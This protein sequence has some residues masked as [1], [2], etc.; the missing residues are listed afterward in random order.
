MG[1]RRRAVGLAGA[2]AL[3]VSLLPGRSSAGGLYFSDRGVRPLGRAGAF[4]AGADDAGSIAYNP[5]GIA[6][7]GNQLL[8]DASWLQYSSVYQRRARLQQID[9]NTGD[10]VGAP[11]EQT[12]PAVEGSTP[13]LPIPTIVYTDNFGLKDHNFA[14]GLWA[15]YSAITSYPERVNGQPAPQRYSLL[16][17]NGSA[18][19][20][21]GVYGSWMPEK[22]VALGAGIEMLT[23]YFQT[24][25]VFS[26][27]VPDRF[28]CAPEQP[29]YDATS[30][31]RVGPIFAP[32]GVI[33]AIVQPTEIVKI[34]ASFHLPVWISAPATVS[35]R[36]PT[37]SVFD[38]ARQDGDEASVAFEL[39]YTLRTGIEVTPV[40]RLNFEVGFAYEGWGMHD[41][42]TVTP[43]NI[44]LR[45][46]EAFPAEYRVSELSIQRGFE[47][48]W[49][50][51]VGAE[52]GIE[53]GSYLIDLRAGVMYEKSAIPPAYLNASTIDLD[54]TTF[55]GGG[56]LHIGKW[57]FDAVIARVIGTSVEVGLDEQR[58]PQVNPVEANEPASP[59]YVNAGTYQASATVLGVGL[60]YQ[61]D[62]TKEPP[63]RPGTAP[64]PETEPAREPVSSQKPKAEAPA[65]EDDAFDKAFE[66]ETG[67]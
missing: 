50:A 58:I 38:N 26:A 21:P 29:E 11:Y 67:D 17:L 49:S 4:V 66:K 20:I 35:V 10:P 51:R 24:S 53:A 63:T 16:T 22:N 44:A 55:A 12:F 37:A 8:V 54:K 27:C 42:I 3:A 45:D 6:F 19:A 15:P 23:G 33:G 13:V 1:R 25:V 39:P 59:H 28:I 18:L 48:S 5:A 31:L 60:V 9:P 34:G 56:S 41:E 30:Q 32:S 47:N 64:P 7:A 40:E 43:E 2:A 61:F 52:L 57:R 14:I 46:V 62:S 36:L 65:D